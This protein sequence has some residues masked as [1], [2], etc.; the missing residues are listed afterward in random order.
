MPAPSVDVTI[1]PAVISDGSLTATNSVLMAYAAA[2]GPTAPIVV[3]SPQEAA[4]AGV[5]SAALQHVSDLLSNGV[6]QVVLTRVNTAVA[7]A[8]TVDADGWGEA[9]GK[10]DA[11]NYPLGQAMIPGIGTADAHEA[12]VAF[13]QNTRRCAYLDAPLNATAAA[14]I[15]LVDLQAGSPD[16][17]LTGMFPDWA[18]VRAGGSQTRV[19]PGSIAAAGPTARMDKF[20]GHSNRMPAGPQDTP[21]TNIVRNAIGVAS[22]R[23]IDELN[24]FAEAGVN[25]L[26]QIPEG[27]FLWD[28]LSI[29]DDPLWTN[30]S[31]APGVTNPRSQLSWGRLAMQILGDASSGLRQFLFQQNDGQ[32]QLLTRAENFLGSYLAGLWAVNAIYGAEAD[33]SYSANVLG[34]TTAA[35]VASGTLRAAISFAPTPSVRFVTL[36]ATVTRAGS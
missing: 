9:L 13:S 31:S 32:G 3:R 24:A 19:I 21:V 35:D 8:A 11:V 12:L 34:V 33:D 15:A 26:R 2:T 14:V 20:A 23:T 36:Q 28:F 7:D 27:V 25:P 4:T 16:T 29:T 6:Q 22:T 10:L 1:A 30:L 18:I 5:T 17:Y